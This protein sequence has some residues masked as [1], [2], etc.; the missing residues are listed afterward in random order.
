MPRDKVIAPSLTPSYLHPCPATPL[1]IL[2]S[3]ISI[4]YHLLV[5]REISFGERARGF[6]FAASEYRIA[7]Y[8]RSIVTMPP[9]MEVHTHTHMRT[10]VHVYFLIAALLPIII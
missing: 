2:L 5:A 8:S 6:R 9:R 1:A 7:K 4:L 3:H 10:R